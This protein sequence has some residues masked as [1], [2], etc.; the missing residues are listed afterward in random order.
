MAL[1]AKGVENLK[2]P[3]R[4]RDGQVK[5]LYL[6]VTSPTNR[7]WQLRF[8][9]DGRERWMGLGPAREVPLKEAREKAEEARRSLRGGI[10]PIEARRADREQALIETARGLTFR[11]ASE[12]Y[13]DAQQQRWR[14]A[15]HRAQFLSTLKAYAFPVLGAV[16]VEVIS[17]QMV[18][19][20]LQPIWTTKTETASRVRNR[21]EMVLDFC[22]AGGFRKGDNPARWKGN[23]SFILPPPKK[24]TAVR[25]HA[26]VA[27]VEMPA[28]M[29]ELAARGG[30]AARALEFTILTAARTSEVIGAQWNEID[31][32]AKVWTIPPGRM[33]GGREHKVPLPSRAM[34]MLATLPREEGNPHLFIGSSAGRPLSNMAMSTL[35]KRMGRTETVH[36]FRSTFRDWAAES[37]IF[38]NHIV[39]MSLA[40]HLGKTEAAYR[41]GAL[42]A[43]RAQLMEAWAAFLYGPRA[44]TLVFPRRA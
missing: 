18:F 23:L 12:R 9:V 10:N 28:F 6:V 22:T 32:D 20:A 1:T 16:S 35:L 19:K 26:A 41:R 2:A 8:Q 44:V 42:L 7:S 43:H 25:H 30:V 13:Y 34:E 29:E 21:I 14:N 15:K 24:V 31:T 3:G 37:T 40:H 33:K 4:Y 39:E 17:T 27:Y 36:G 11:E 38:D 5:G